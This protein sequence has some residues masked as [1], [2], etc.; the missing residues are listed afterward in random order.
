MP[1]TLL[2]VEDEES[3]AL[4]FRRALKSAG[5]E[6]HCEIVTTGHDAIRYLAG[7]G[8]LNDLVRVPL[9][10]LVLL[11][12]NLPDLHGCDVLKRIRESHGAAVAIVVFT[13]S[14][15]WRDVH[16]AYELG[17]NGYV[18]KPGTL[19]QLKLLVRDLCAF[20]LTHNH[21]PT[22]PQGGPGIAPAGG[23]A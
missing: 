2:L 21:L 15:E 11:D 20:W 8:H 18:V 6:L 4:L 23:Y 17:A 5:M 7:D 1:S 3:D 14:R 19:N 10:S 13:S 16:Q 9:P 22:P 12:L